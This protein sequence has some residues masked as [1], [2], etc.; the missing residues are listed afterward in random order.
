M[1]TLARYKPSRNS[2]LRCADL[3]TITER[4]L[5]S[6]VNAVTQLFGSEQAELSSRRLATRVNRNQWSALS[7]PRMAID[8]C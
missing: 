4:E 8:Q 5:S 2:S 6:F 1:N 7:Q 3:A